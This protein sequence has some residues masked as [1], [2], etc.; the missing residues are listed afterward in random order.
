MRP[1]GTQCIL[2]GVRDLATVGTQPVKTRTRS[3]LTWTS[4]RGTTDR[5]TVLGGVVDEV[6]Q[7]G[8]DVR[9]HT[10]RDRADGQS[11]RDFPTKQRPFPSPQVV[12]SR[13]LNSTT[14]ASDAHPARH[15][16]PGGNRL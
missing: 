1:A 11:Q 13:R 10:G 3:S 6:Q 2:S 9:V 4:P 15:P 7:A 5:P 14:A 16:L 8:L 12:L